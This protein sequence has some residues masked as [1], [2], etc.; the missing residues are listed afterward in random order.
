MRK[1]TK[2]SAKGYCLFLM[3]LL[4]AFSRSA[5]Q[6]TLLVS[7]KIVTGKNAPLK[8]VSVSVEGHGI[9][10]VFTDSSG[11]FEIPVPGS[12]VWLIV[13]P[14]GNYEDKRV[15]PG[16]R[17][18]LIIWLAARGM[19]SDNDQVLTSFA[20]V[21]RN[22]MISSFTDIDLERNPYDDAGTINQLLQ[23]SVPGFWV[24]EHCGMPG[25]GMVGF[26][27]GIHSKNA[28][29]APLVVVDGIPYEQPG[30]FE[31]KIQGSFYSPLSDIDPQDISRLSVYSDPTATAIYGTKASNG[32]ILIQTLDPK[33]TQTSI[34]ISLQRGLSF[35]PDRY[36]PQLD[37]NQYLVLAN[38]VLGSSK[39]EPEE[40]EINFPGLYTRQDDDSYFRYMH[41]T[42]WQQYLFSNAQSTNVYFSMNGGSEIGTYGL[43]VGYNDQDGIFTNS[44]YNRFNVRFV[45]YLN[46]FPR[47]NM[48]VTSNL[49]NGNASLKESA[50]SE[51]VSPVLTS[52]FKPPLMN[53][54]QYD[55][56][57]NRLSTIDDVDELGTSNPYALMR[58]YIGD[59]K[60]Y[61]FN[62]SIKGQ[63]DISDP[64][65]FIT[66]IGLNFNTMKEFVFR[67]NLG[68]ETYFDGEAISVSQSTNNYLFSFYNDNHLGFTRSFGRIHSISAVTG[69]RIYTNSFQA[70]FGQA[71][72]LP[73]DD[74][75]TRLQAGQ[76]A[77]RR[78]G[79]INSR[80]NWASAY[81]QV[82][83]KFKDKYIVNL[84]GS[85]DFSTRTGK[86]SVTSLHL[87]DL[88]VGLFYSM[89]AGWRISQESFLRDV[90]G[91]DNLLIRVTYGK[92]GNDDI[93][94]VNALDY[95]YVTRYRETSGL[96]PASSSNE[97]LK[98]EEL[99]KLT[100]GIDGSLRGGRIRFSLEH[101]RSYASD[102]LVY[103]PQ[104][105]YLGYS[106]YPTN[107]GSLYNT[108]FN[109]SAY[110]RVYEGRYF[111]WELSGWLSLLSNEVTAIPGNELVTPVPGGEMVTRTG[112]P[113]NC[114]YGYLFDGV[115]AGQQ[116]VQALNLVNS[117]GMPYGPGDAIYRDISGPGGSPDGIINDFD[118]EIL[119]SPLPDFFGGI[120]NRF[121]YGR[122]ALDMQVQFIGG[123]ELF[124]Y[125]RYMNERMTDLSN[126]SISVLKRWQYEGDETDVP[127]ALWDDPIGNADFSSRWIED[128]S[129]VRLKH[130]SIS[131]STPGSFLTF[132]NATFYISA[133]NLVT[134]H[135]YLGYDPE[136]S[137]S[138]DPMT[139]GAD[140]GLMPQYRKFLVGFKIG[141]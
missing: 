124:N 61:R 129:F 30:L 33:S 70:D 115:Y 34:R 2:I 39:L 27:D 123:N 54:F 81:S 117:K 97:T 73:D 88:P 10:P 35:A 83:Y 109:F 107:A 101:F 8:D 29:N 19:K 125:V 87:P 9:S 22:D 118:K 6:D 84:G 68:M 63:L 45:S 103:E 28:S 23:G 1:V 38:E 41:N 60:N 92:T 18:S 100:A 89:G 71:M 62:S 4:A 105:S 127:R 50:V 20:R 67:P 16:G 131:Y 40:F 49:V 43:S 104:E 36:I 135:R 59:S 74:E 55:D 57:G 114:F 110:Q 91:L 90:S 21:A 132:K 58:N 139:L 140:Y 7:G 5:G 75:Y 14:L 77:L 99:Q 53:P 113:V 11:N 17:T 26:L 96:I 86:K 25:Q 78:L 12:D 102:L 141:L 136:F 106:Y 32:L 31:S 48:I 64:L 98:Y 120:T 3:L 93:G 137:Y 95:Y 46:I 42:N 119:G 133:L 138:Y 76:S 126:Q 44:G 15:F 47:F 108:G 51:E 72:N 69:L 121:L 116:E 79:G 122:W 13:D 82:A 111:I 24:T 56:Q 37:R 94:N 52:L 80:W 85:A 65:K 112:M 130:L 128:G 66:L 134:L